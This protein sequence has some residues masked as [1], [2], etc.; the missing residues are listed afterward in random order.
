MAVCW[1]FPGKTVTIEAPCLDCGAPM[2]LEM[3]D[4]VVLKADP[5][6]IVGY[7]SVPF[8]KWMEHLPH[9]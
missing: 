8:S 7:V 4:G 5:E 3:K 2:H 9:A 6:E 1:L